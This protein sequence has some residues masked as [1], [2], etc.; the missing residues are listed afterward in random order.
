MKPSEFYVGVLDFFAILLPGAIATAILLPRY[1]DLIVG[2]LG[3]ALTSDASKWVAFLVCA[4]F[5]GH[6]IFLLGSYIDYLY[7]SL[8]E[9]LSPYD[10]ESAFQCAMKIRDSLVNES[11][12]KA[13][14][15]FQWS[16]SVLISVCPAAAEDVHRLEADSKFFRSLLVVCALAAIAFFV[17]HHWMEGSIAFALVAPCFARY[18]ERRLK[19]TTQ[20]YIHIVTLHRLGKLQSHPN[21]HAANPSINTDAA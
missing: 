15:T 17:S 3:I 8:R 19:S 10:N 12:R 2:P 7:N 20:A 18:Y 11:E 9:K 21:A 16:R 6:L 14:N 4:Y 13:L 1:G 5:A